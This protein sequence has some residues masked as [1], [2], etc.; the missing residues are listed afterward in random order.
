MLMQTVSFNKDDI[1]LLM[2]EAKVELIRRLAKQKHRPD[3]YEVGCQ[4]AMTLMSVIDELTHEPLSDE[5]RQSFSIGLFDGLNAF[6]RPELSSKTII[7]D[8]LTKH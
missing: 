4:M 7:G 2:D 6:T 3:P 5:V 1:D 8:P